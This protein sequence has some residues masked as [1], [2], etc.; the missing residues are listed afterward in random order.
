[1]LVVVA[2]ALPTTWMLALAFLAHSEW[3][4]SGFE[5]CARAFGL[6]QPVSAYVGM[7]AVLA[8]GVG[9]WR[10][11][12]ALRMHRRLRH[13]AP[14]SVEV[15]GH[16]R[17]FAYTLPGRGG[18]IVL[19]SALVDLLDETE[20]EIV[21]A[22]E[23]AHARH[24][25]DRYLLAGAITTAT[26]PLLRPLAS[27]L[28]YSVERWAD[29]AAASRCG[30]RRLVARTLGKVALGQAQLRGVLPFA[31]LGVG[32]RVA[33]LLAAPPRG[34]RP[35]SVVLLWS[36][37]AVTATLALYQLHHLGALAAALCPH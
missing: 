18:H 37:I 30:D 34:P 9:T 35:G 32:A 13:D 1:M 26:I 27:R 23:L 31:G 24:R 4:G 10:G 16:E 22:H 12:R 29:E 8:G 21:V 15:A 7:P 6:H 2:A 25:H 20:R 5:W 17:P 14:G 28:E 11:V 3:L 33:A 19:S 36:G